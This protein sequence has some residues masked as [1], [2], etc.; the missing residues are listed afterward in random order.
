MSGR[1]N[2]EGLNRAYGKASFNITVGHAT[3]VR[4]PVG[5]QKF[6]GCT[7]I[8][9]PQPNGRKPHMAVKNRQGDIIFEV[10]ARQTAAYRTLGEHV[11]QQLRRFTWEEFDSD[12]EEDRTYLK[13]ELQ[14]ELRHRCPAGAK[15]IPR[16]ILDTETTGLDPRVDEILQLSIIDGDGRTILDRKY[17]P[18]HNTTWREAE[19][20]HHISPRDVADRPNISVDLKEIQTILDRANEICVYNADF[21]ISFLGELGLLVDPGKITDTMTEYGRR[22][23]RTKYWR[24]GDAAAECGY[25]YHAH[26]ALEDCRAT[27]AVQHRLDGLVPKPASRTRRATTAAKQ[28]TDSKTDRAGS[29]AR[30]H[31]TPVKTPA[32]PPSNTPAAPSAQPSETPH[33]R[34]AASPSRVR[35]VSIGVLYWILLASGVYMVF[36]AFSDSRKWVWAVM[37]V[38]SAVICGRRRRRLRARTGSGQSK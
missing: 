15:P 7:V 18:G 19:Q 37:L 25:S 32:G 3:G 29:S 26:D 10:N 31:P 13:C 36:G 11:G 1:E 27:L 24:L 35:R 22:Y 33:A 8:S 23:H 17:K 2:R 4:K 28:L 14:T 20:V 21:D 12:F 6:N 38:A 5:K 16:I 34:H 30:P 9:I